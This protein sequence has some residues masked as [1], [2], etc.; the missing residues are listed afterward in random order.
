MG[1]RWH[2]HQRIPRHTTILAGHHEEAIVSYREALALRPR[3]AN[4]HFRVGKA[5]EAL[6]RH[7]EALKSYEQALTINPTHVGALVGRGDELRRFG[8]YPE[9]AEVL[10]ALIQRGVCS[11]NLLLGLANMP[12]SVVTIDILAQLDRVTR[13]DGEAPEIFEN[14][15]RFARAAALDKAGRHAEAWEHL[16]AAN[17][18]AFLA[19]QEGFGEIAKRQAESLARLRQSSARQ[20]ATS[21]DRQVISLF[22]LGPSRCGK[23]TLESL[24]STLDGVKC[25]YEDSTAQNAVTRTFQ[26]AA[27]PGTPCWKTCLRAFIQ[28]VAMHT[29]PNWPNAPDPPR[30]SPARIQDGSMMPIWSLLRFPT[31]DFYY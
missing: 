1:R 11:A 6:G 10:Q 5:C 24:V 13:Q 9:A 25:G 29:C 21:D 4:L 27:L 22:I 8:K 18:A 28:H 3:D 7:D 14:F 12:A 20:A 23:T 26:A 17:R 19:S 2:S 31:S 15:V 30:S 16:V